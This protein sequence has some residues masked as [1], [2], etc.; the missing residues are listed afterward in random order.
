MKLSRSWFMFGGPFHIRYPA[1]FLK[2]F[3]HLR[4][5]LLADISDGIPCLF[6]FLRTLLWYWKP[7][8]LP[9]PFLIF[10]IFLL[11]MKMWFPSCSDCQTLWDVQVDNLFTTL[12]LLVFP[13]FATTTIFYVH[14]LKQIFL[15]CKVFLPEHLPSGATM[16]NRRWCYNY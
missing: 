4:K 13:N 9:T 7:E 5:V 15:T 2:L 1:N 10:P 11:T 8:L 14:K 6:V 3:D 12:D 16:I